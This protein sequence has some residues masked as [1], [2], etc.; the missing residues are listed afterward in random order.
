MVEVTTV[1][2]LVDRLRKGKYRSNNEIRTRSAYDILLDFPILTGYLGSSVIQSQN[3]DD[4]IVVGQQTIS[5]KCP[6][7]CMLML[8]MNQSYVS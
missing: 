1:A 8:L 2:Q 4:E 5:L 3:E 6:V 7:S